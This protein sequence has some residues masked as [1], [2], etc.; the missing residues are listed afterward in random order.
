[1]LKSWQIHYI[2]NDDLMSQDSDELAPRGET[3]GT[4]QLRNRVE[5]PE[6]RESRVTQDDNRPWTM[7]LS[8]KYSWKSKQATEPSAVK[9]GLTNAP[10]LCAIPLCP[11]CERQLANVSTLF[12][13][14][15]ALIQYHHKSRI[16]AAVSTCY[17]LRLEIMFVGC[18]RHIYWLLSAERRSTQSAERH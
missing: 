5:A 10:Y 11:L 2:Y 13:G 14:L 12:I 9:R 17:R 18:A 4:E 7:P 16:R 1:M 8:N 3:H 6:E 15:G